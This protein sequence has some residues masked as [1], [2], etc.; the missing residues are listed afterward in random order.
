MSPEIQ[1]RVI[2]RLIA[3]G[4]SDEPWALIVLAAMEGAEQLDGFLD[5]KTSV[6][7]PQKLDVAGGVATEPPGAYVSSI[8][9]EGFRGIG[10]ATTLTLRPGPG[11]TLVV[12]RN[13]SGKSSFAE[14]LEYLLTGRNYRWE[15]RPKVWLEA[16]ATSI[17]IAQRSRAS[18]SSKD[19]GA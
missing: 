5:K 18:S 6:A 1:A 4:K 17:T 11:L 15:K 14:G 3:S 19:W 16:G 9:V 13:G 12:G 10:P 7:P 2:D 8:A